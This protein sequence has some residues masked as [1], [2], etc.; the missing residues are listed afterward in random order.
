MTVI[1]HRE[2]RNNSAEI[3]RRVAAGESFVVTNNG[4][5]AAHLLPPSASTAT[6]LESMRAQGK[7]RPAVT[8]PDFTAMRGASG[9]SSRE[10]LE[11]LRGDR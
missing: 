6:P 10:V 1:S 11:D 5:A 2:F 4:V 8:R 3:L 9:V 7:T